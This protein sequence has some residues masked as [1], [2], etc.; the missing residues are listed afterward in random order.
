[1]QLKTVHT[2][3]QSPKHNA[4]TDLLEYNDNLLCC[5]REA[6]NHISG[7]GVIRII[8]LDHAGNKQWQDRIV[9]PGA[10]LR[11]PKLI[12]LPNGDV[13]LLAYARFADEHNR[14]RY[15]RSLV[16]RT[17][18]GKSWSQPRYFGPSY[19]WLWRLRWVNHTAFGLAYNRT[20]QRLD[21]YSGNPF[22]TFELH[23]RN[24][25]G[26]SKHQ[27]GYPNESDLL[28]ASDNSLYALVRRDADTC[29]AQFGVATPPYKQWQW[30]DLG[31]Y[32]GS[33][34]MTQLNDGDLLI[35][36]RQ[37]I[38]NQPKTVVAKLSIQDI[39]KPLI[40]N[41]VVLPSAGDNGYPGLV[42]QSDRALI[43]Y[44][45]QH[46]NRCCQIYLAE[47]ML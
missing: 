44:Y 32:F 47:I 25:L 17:N 9:V 35:A 30:F 18:T 24:V 39:R 22:G 33:P 46:E 10:D 38:N 16:W 21:L 11:D 27:L 2:I 1:M 15:T 6:S 4:F 45:S 42:L 41:R 14:T 40:H 20:E 5:F 34:V 36:G 29:T 19:W 8:T 3:W 23:Q 28:L 13:V 31:T 37:W 43:S 12:T 26:L 7:D